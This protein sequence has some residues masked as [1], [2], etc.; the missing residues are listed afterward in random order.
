[1]L[2]FPEILIC[3]RS[4]VLTRVKQVPNTSGQGDEDSYSRSEM[5]NVFLFIPVTGSSL[6]ALQTPSL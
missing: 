3:R 6:G 5:L 1:M 2:C 4:K